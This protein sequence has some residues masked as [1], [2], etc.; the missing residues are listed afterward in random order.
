MQFCAILQQKK[1][2]YRLIL[3]MERMMG[4]WLYI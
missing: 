4:M 3:L 1:P 2:F